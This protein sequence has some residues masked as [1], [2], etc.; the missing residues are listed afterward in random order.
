MPSFVNKNVNAGSSGKDPT[1]GGVEEQYISGLLDGPGWFSAFSADAST[2][3]NVYGA[4][5]NSGDLSDDPAEGSPVKLPDDGF[6]PNDGGVGG[7][8]PDLTPVAVTS[9]GI[10]FNLTFDSAAPSSFRAGIVQAASLLT[11]AISDQITLNLSIHYTNV[12]TNGGAFAS[13]NFSNGLFEGYSTT[14]AALINSASPGDTIFNALPSG[15]SIQ[16]QSQVAVWS[17]QLKALGFLSANSAINDGSA[18]FATNIASNALVGV[19]LHELTHAMGRIPYGPPYSNSPDIFDLFRFTSPNTRLFSGVVD[20]APPAYFSVNGG[21]TKLADYGQTSDTSDFLNSGVQGSSDPFN[22]FFNPGSTS[23][24]LSAV[25][26]LQL[27][28]LGFHL[29]ANQYVVIE[30]NGS[31]TLY[32]GANQAYYLGANG[33][34]SGA[35]QLLT[36]AG[37]AIRAGQNGSWTPIGAEHNASGGYQVVWKNGGAAQF[38]V[39]TTDSN[40]AF[41]GQ[42]NIVG[43]ESWYVQSLEAS[44]Q[45]DLNG[46][47]QIGAVTSTIEAAASTSVVK[48]AD[49]FF[50]YAHGTTSGPQLKQSGAYVLP[51]AW[52]PIGAEHNASGG[53]QVV[54]KNFTPFTDQYLVWTTD[55]GGN[56]T[57]QTNIVGSGSWYVQSLE[58]SFQQDLNS[59]TVIGA[60]TSTIEASGSTSVA[61]V[62]DS[63][64]L[65]AHGTTTGPQLMYSGAYVQTGAWVPI[66]AEHNASGGY[67]VVLKNFTAGADQFVLWTTDS[68][69]NFLSSGGVMS[70]SSYAMEALEPTFQQDFNMDGTT[71]V[72][73]VA[74][75]SSGSTK[76]ARVADFYFMYQGT[77]TSGTVLRYGGASV[78]PGTSP[79]TPRAAEQVGSGYQVV[80]KPGSADQYIVWTTDSGGNFQSS[81]GVMSG[82]S[83]T[84]EAL[85]ATFQQDLNG[86]GTTGVVS[87]AIDSVGTAKLAKVADFY[88]LY[89]GTGATGSVL[90]YNGAAVMVGASPW[91]PLGAE[92]SGSGYKVVFRN[93]SADQYVAWNTDSSGNFLFSTPVVS[94]SS[95]TLIGLETS[96]NQDLNGNGPVGAARPMMTSSSESTGVI[97][98]TGNDSSASGN[99]ALLTNYMASTFVAPPGEGTGAVV[100]AEPP[101]QGLLTATKRT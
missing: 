93:G 29:T 45:Q 71:G 76:L 79:W 36:I 59:D 47:G 18:S 10:T 37:G 38:Q 97:A 101:D 52:V 70:G 31:T 33:A 66:G 50:L 100:A 7:S 74:I 61:K 60:V 25:D 48:V 8:P 77:G 43:P 78:V 85:E 53:Y 5:A 63:F 90:R 27:D 11:A 84:M 83:Y 4:P 24:Q 81:S 95:A 30:Q 17:S 15:S 34:G 89:Q 46:D 72:V 21:S 92:V 57:G 91:T 3:L 41:T 68:S 65:Y 99:L 2:A 12:G 19:A 22:E 44:F 51:S 56:F 6:D 35:A 67:Q 80:L 73:S 28:A 1:S 69:G 9:G 87:T 88:F 32:R 64:F 54:W 75:E 42:T 14:R 58:S 13:P 20:S 62:A 40:A 26:L 49:S 55:S 82:S 96:F 16:G 23:Q 39:W 98:E 94:G 86:D